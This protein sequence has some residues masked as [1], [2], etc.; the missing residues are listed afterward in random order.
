MPEMDGY[1]TTA[2]I[3]EIPEFADLPVIA[4][5]ARA[6]QGD[7]DK[8]L[9]A[10]ATDYVTKPVDTEELLSAAWSA[11]CP[12]TRR[13]DPGSTDQR[14]QQQ[15][16]VAELVPQ[17]AG[18]L[19]LPVGGFDQRRAGDRRQQREVGRARLVPAAD[20]PG[21]HPGR[22]L[23]SE[24]QAGQAAAG[25]DGVPRRPAPGTAGPCSAGL[26]SPGFSGAGLCTA[27]LS[28]A[29]VQVVPTAITRR[30]AARVRLTR[31]AVGC[32]TSNHSGSG[33]SPA[34]SEATPVCR[35]MGAIATPAAIS[36]VTSSAVNGRAAL[37]ISA[38]P[39]VR[40]NP[41]GRR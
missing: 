19:G 26:S 8:S 4:V 9:A 17:V 34:S 12:L 27:A 13:A 6:M 14:R 33:A 2:A 38:L 11:G 3:R 41:S 30:P 40:A 18:C 29:L 25:G 20:Q 36:L 1:A 37:A 35:V 15:A 5:T 31:S 16:A 21:D 22:V 23:R 7:R 10:G 24:H 39:G 32:G 28:R